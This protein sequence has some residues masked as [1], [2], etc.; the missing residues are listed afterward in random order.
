MACIRSH[1]GTWTLVVW[2]GCAG[3][4]SLA[5]GDGTPGANIAGLAG[6]GHPRT[7]LDV[8]P[9]G[10]VGGSDWYFNRG[11]ALARQGDSESA[12]DVLREG[13][14]LFPDDGR[15]PRELAGVHFKLKQRTE[16]IRWMRRALRI[17]PNDA[18][19]NDFLGTVY[20]LEG[21]LR[22]ALVHWNR[23]G[24]PRIAEV[25]RVSDQESA[26]AL[27][28]EAC[29][30]QPGTVLSVKTLDAC[31]TNL[32]WLGP[33][34]SHRIVLEPTGDTE[35]DVEVRYVPRRSGIHS[36][37]DLVPLLSGVPFKMLRPELLFNNGIRLQSVLRW[38][39]NQ[40]QLEATVSGPLGGSAK[41]RGTVGLDIRRELWSGSRDFRL[42]AETVDARVSWPI[43][44]R[45]TVW[46]GFSLQR[47]K[48][49]VPSE[50]SSPSAVPLED[51]KFVFSTSGLRRTWLPSTIPGVTF[52]AA[53]AIDVGADVG[54][55]TRRLIRSVSSLEAAW[56]IPGAWREL[57]VRSRAT[58]GWLSGEAS[59]CQM[60]SLGVD[61]EEA[62]QLRG[63][64]GTNDGK[65]G[66]GP[67]GRALAL[68]NLD[69]SATV[70]RTR[71]S[72]LTAG[73]FLDLAH[74]RA[75]EGAVDAQPWFVDA[76][77]VARLKLFDGLEIA[78]SFGRDLMS[79]T[80]LFHVSI[81]GR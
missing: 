65:K 71:I 45:T 74:L 17:S 16:A 35:F 62:L 58:A 42:N 22:S 6:A 21:D 8:A 51:G 81:V 37:M 70:H 48:F 73:P 36:G 25:K 18:Y 27:M 75:P 44:G 33:A 41:A 31:E 20:S 11:L 32:D 47:F 46:T 39:P 12:A 76:G 43:S 30:L 61:Q 29:P 67:R 23:I 68:T 64:R 15:F 72:R 53:S 57:E 79:S 28:D 19:A 55:T 24:K 7:N 54:P 2:L 69:V 49:D 40:R 38:D 66:S 14:R 63:H 78:A 52:D 1:A 5:L 77:V 26:H 34:S 10:L 3:Q 50:P 9:A 80:D 59:V 13:T 4:I 60:F 56:R